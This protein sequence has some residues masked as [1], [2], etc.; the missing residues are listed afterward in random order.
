[1]LKNKDFKREREREREREKERK[2][3]PRHSAMVI[4]FL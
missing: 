2:L 1:M 3:T 4:Y